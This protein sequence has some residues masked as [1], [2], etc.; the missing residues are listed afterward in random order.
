[1]TYA[2]EYPTLSTRPLRNMIRLYSSPLNVHTHTLATSYLPFTQHYIAEV[3]EHSRM[4]N[5][6][7]FC[8]DMEK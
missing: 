4:L 3:L 6:H 5:Q 7:S 2:L 1:M 8:S